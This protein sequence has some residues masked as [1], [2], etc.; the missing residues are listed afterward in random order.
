MINKLY[1][2]D[3]FYF[4]PN[5]KK[6]FYYRYFKRIFLFKRCIY[7]KEISFDEWLF[8]GDEYVD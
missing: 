5:Q 8:K 7:N 4:G 3:K 2:R 1:F 6:D